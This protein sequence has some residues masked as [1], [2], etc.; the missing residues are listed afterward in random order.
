MLYVRAHEQ[1]NAERKL[2]PEE[3]KAKKIKKLQ[4]DTSLG[5]YVAVY[6][7]RDLS[8]PAKKFKVDKNAQQFFATGNFFNK[9]VRYF[10]NLVLLI[11]I[12]W[13]YYIIYSLFIMLVLRYLEKLWYC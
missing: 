12:I 4:E 3:R 5:V 13:G 10:S 11:V 7:L 1:A 2:T 6:R 9:V 8:D